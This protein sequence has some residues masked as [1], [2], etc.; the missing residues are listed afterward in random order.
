MGVESDAVLFAGVGSGPLAPS[1]ATVAVLLIA[2][3]P[4][5]SGLATVTAKVESAL[6]PPAIAPR[7]RVQDEPAGAPFAQLQPAELDPALKLVLAGTVSLTTTPVA[8]VLEV[9]VTPRL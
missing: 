7:F 1:S 4:P 6:P 2:V 5:G 9:L 8:V 3:V